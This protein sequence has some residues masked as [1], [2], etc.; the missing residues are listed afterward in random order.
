MTNKP[1]S[2]HVFAISTLVTFIFIIIIIN[3]PYYIP[4]RSKYSS[5][6]R[7]FNLKPI[8][9]LYY[10]FYILE[11]GKIPNYYGKGVFLI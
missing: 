2:S 3:I 1:D 6:A 10:A 9:Y 8:Y 5:Q 4:N 11:I 7:D